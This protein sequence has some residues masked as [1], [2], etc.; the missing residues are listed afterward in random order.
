MAADPVR[1]RRP[2]TQWH[3]RPVRHPT[4]ALVVLAAGWT[5]L[6]AAADTVREIEPPTHPLPEEAASAGIS[7]FSFIAYGDT[8]SRLDGIELQ[9][10][11]ALVVDSM[12]ET[13]RRLENS[14]HP[15]RFVLQSGDAVVD[16]R[17]AGQWN[18][19]FVDI[20]NRLTTVAGVP[21][22]LAAGN[23]DVTSAADRDAPGRVAGLDN[24]LQAT[25]RLIPPAETSRR[26][27]GYP[28]YAFGYGNTFVV[29]IDSNLAADV[30]QFEWVASQ[31]AGLD[32]ARYRHVIALFHHPI[33]SSGPHGG[34]TLEPQ[35]AALRARYAPLFRRHGVRMTIAG[36][37]H[38]FEHWVERYRDANGN[39]M[40][41]DHIVTGGGGA[42]PYGYAGEPD[43]AA[44][45]AAGAGEAV[46]LEHLVR[47]EVEEAANPYHYLV[48]TVEG[49]DVTVEVVAIGRAVEFE[50]YR[51]R[52]IGIASGVSP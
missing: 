39:P 20:I 31:L 52:R 29:A 44:F 14:D 5:A 33:F 30:T 8:R 36:H 16:G 49:D 48:V 32:R 38:V 21:Y 34:P 41:T 28:T 40:R 7:T 1:P 11:H 23:H 22:F 18:R 50:P 47:P 24:Y 42:P 27:A 9:P 6:S 45:L 3:N 10:E 43:L 35:T 15:V 25:N 4:L 2:G 12:L 13:I 46:Q 19:S 37:D 51:S 26:L 17:E